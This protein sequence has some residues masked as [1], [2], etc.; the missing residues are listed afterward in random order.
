MLLRHEKWQRKIDRKSGSSD[1]KVVRARREYL[2][3]IGGEVW[4]WAADRVWHSWTRHLA[5]RGGL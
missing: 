3:V 2:P 4:R 5:G 1:S